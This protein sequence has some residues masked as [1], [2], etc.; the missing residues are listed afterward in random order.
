LQGSFT[1]TDTKFPLRI[2]VKHFS[3]EASQQ[4]LCCENFKYI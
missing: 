3:L 2:L 4:I 1:N